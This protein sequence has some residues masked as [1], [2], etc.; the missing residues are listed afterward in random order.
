MHAYI[1]T[2]IAAAAA[3][4]FIYLSIHAYIHTHLLTYMRVIPSF[5]WCPLIRL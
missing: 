5:T 4:E 3:G 1:L 2:Y